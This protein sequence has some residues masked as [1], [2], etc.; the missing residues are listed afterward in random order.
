MPQFPIMVIMIT[1]HGDI[2]FR[3][4]NC[5]LNRAACTVP[6][7]GTNRHTHHMARSDEVSDRQ[8]GILQDRLESIVP[9]GT[10]IRLAMDM[11]AHTSD[12]Q[13]ACF[14]SGANLTATSVATPKYAPCGNP[15]I[16]RAATSIGY[17]VDSI[18][19]AAPRN[20]IPLSTISIFF[21]ENLCANGSNNAPMHTPSAYAV[22]QYPASA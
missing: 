2:F 8:N 20:I 6:T 12:T 11:P 5:D 7:S 4:L 9:S 13:K 19:S 16:K 17:D 10:H 22:M 3:K 1:S 21:N 14:P 15:D 18:E